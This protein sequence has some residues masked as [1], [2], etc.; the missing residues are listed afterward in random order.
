MLDT[1]ASAQAPLLGAVLLWAAAVKLF[2]RRG[3]IR[4]QTTALSTLLGKDRAALGY[5][6]L[7]GIEALV[8]AA[9]LLPPLWWPEAA[10]VVVM[11]VGFAGYLAYSRVAAPDSSCGC[12]SSK[13]VPISWRGFT[14]AGW[15]LAAGTLGAFATQYWT[16][17][18]A[19]RP[20]VLAVLAAEAALFVA[21]SPEF[22]GAWL[23]PLRR[24]RVRF[25]DPLGGDTGGVP[26]DATLTRLHREPLY[27]HVAL[28]LRTDV[29]E[30]WDE[31]EYRFVVYGASLDGRSTTAVFAV[32]LRVDAVETLRVAVVDESTGETLLQLDHAPDEEPESAFAG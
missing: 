7:G 9:L 27:R 12:M 32:P 5:R 20:V 25:T 13:H 18:I 11:A 6:A 2:T 4:S 23:I 30:Y 29:Q 15:L 3:R 22:D 24:L 8:G 26:L 28:M 31:D 17:A 10:A 1:I 14:R 16:G 19:D 21:L